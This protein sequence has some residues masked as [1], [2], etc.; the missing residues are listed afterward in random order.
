MSNAANQNGS[1]LEQQVSL[2]FSFFFFQFS[3][4]THLSSSFR[5]SFQQ[6]VSLFRR[7]V[8]CTKAQKAL[9]ENVKFQKLSQTRAWWSCS[10][11]REFL[12]LYIFFLWCRIT[13]FIIW[14]ATF[15]NCVQCFTII[16]SYIPSTEIL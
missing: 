2:T 15:F 1:G 7:K 16:F 8:F 13:V 3:C 4:H 6:W 5:N 14:L 12:R 9:K 11:A 10:R